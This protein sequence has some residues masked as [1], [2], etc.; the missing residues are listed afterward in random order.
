VRQCGAKS[1]RDK[2]R[3]RIA[4]LQSLVG[5]LLFDS[6]KHRV[7]NGR[8]AADAFRDEKQNALDRHS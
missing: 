1:F 8:L 3:A 7:H 2:I 6:V 4:K 5:F